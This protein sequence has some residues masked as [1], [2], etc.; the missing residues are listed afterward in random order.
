MKNTSDSDYE[1]KDEYTLDYSQGVRG[2]Y[3]EA[4]MRSKGFAKLDQDIL[5]AFPSN[6]DL[7]AALHSLMQASRH[8]KLSAASL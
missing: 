2:K 8:V 1:L 6:Q 7:N 3:H 5:E 4:A